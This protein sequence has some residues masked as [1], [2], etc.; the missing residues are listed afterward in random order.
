MKK[1]WAIGL[2]LVFLLV[3][4]ASAQ[5]PAK[6]AELTFVNDY[7]R[8][9]SSGEAQQL[10]ALLSGIERATTAEVIIVTV[11]NLGGDSAF[12]FAQ[13]LYTRWGI[14]K[15]D[16][17]NGLLILVSTSEREFRMHTGYGLEGALP[18]GYLGGLYRDYIV[19]SFGAGRYYE[20]LMQVL[21]NGIVPA[22]E[23]EYN[24]TITLDSHY[25]SFR[26]P[27]TSWIEQYSSILWI[28][29]LL[30]LLSNRPGRSLLWFLLGTSFGRGGG[31]YRG[32]GGRG[33]FGGG[34]S[35]GGGAG[36][37]W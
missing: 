32:G 4:P 22:L 33:G 3:S 21:V 17:N 9:L 6:P 16:K 8:I 2:I 11:N 29:L 19:P 26:Q 10:S 7:A 34:R 5:V 24:R 1:W 25:A 23:K 12:G 31:S 28:I 27:R 14:G 36:G 30:F 15:K 13:E 20:G 37:R 18:D 35:G